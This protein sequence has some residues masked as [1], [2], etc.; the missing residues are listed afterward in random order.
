MNWVHPIALL[1]GAWILAFLQSWC[2]GLRSVIHAQP[3]LLAGLVIYSALHASLST[4]VG[5][6]MV[7]G[8]GLDT[9]SSGPFGLGAVPLLGLGVMLHRR[10]D[11]ILR[12]SSWAQASIGGVGSLGVAVASFLLLYILWP[13]VSDGPGQVPFQPEV[14]L[15]LS[16]LPGAGLGRLWQC[17][18]AG[19]VGAVST[20]LLFRLFRWVDATCN[21]QPAPVMARR[22]DREIERGRS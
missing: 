21:Y 1:I 6:A 12:D 5:V 20:P 15:G 7:G 11:L 17:L 14:V 10:R 3:D 2:T 19:V 22:S 18:V 4:T 9:L 8:L 16:E 13:L